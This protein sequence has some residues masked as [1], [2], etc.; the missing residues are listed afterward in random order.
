MKLQRFVVLD[1]NYRPD[2]EG[3]W[4]ADGDVEELESENESLR[5][6]LARYENDGIT[7]AAGCWSS[8]PKHYECALAEIERLKAPPKVL[9]AEEVTEPGL[10]W[11][12]ESTSHS[13]SKVPQI[14]TQLGEYRTLGPITLKPRFVF[15]SHGSQWD[16][17]R[18][19][20]GQFIGPLTPPGVS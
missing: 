15:G 4:C 9:S 7:H 3:E 11:W 14:V 8:G 10:Y 13:W 19:F 18:D 20:Q 17:S 1:D 6:K 5:A 2:D 12:R 16:A